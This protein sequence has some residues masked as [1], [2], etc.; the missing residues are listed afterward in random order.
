MFNKINPRGIFSAWTIPRAHGVGNVVAWGPHLRVQ[1]CCK[2]C[3]FATPRGE[4]P[5]TEH[6]TINVWRQNS[7]GTGERQRLC[8][9][10]VVGQADGVV[11]EMGDSL[12]G[13]GFNEEQG[14]EGGAANFLLDLGKS[15]LVSHDADAVGSANFLLRGQADGVVNE[16]GDS[17]GGGG[18]QRR[19]RR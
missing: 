10:F 1:L 8:Q 12:G 17:L 13:G 11:N 15:K 16:M 18:L 5:P 3:K 14:D 19:T 7:R 6:T 4:K 9:F 2:N